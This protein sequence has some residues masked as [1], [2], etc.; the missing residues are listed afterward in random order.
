MALRDV[1]KIIADEN[2]RITSAKL[3]SY[4]KELELEMSNDEIRDM[5]KAVQPNE[6]AGNG[7]DGT[8]SYYSLLL[9]Y[10]SIVY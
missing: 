10:V 3:R 9:Y 5:I 2:G 7:Y 1:F 4:A 6:K 8:V